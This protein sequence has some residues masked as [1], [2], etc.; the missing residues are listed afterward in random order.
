MQLWGFIRG[1]QYIILLALIDLNLPAL[2]T[3]FFEDA[4]VV[5]QMDIFLGEEIITAVFNF[6]SNE[7]MNDLFDKYSF[8][9][10]N[11][12]LNSG[13][14][15][16][17]LAILLVL[18]SV[19]FKVVNWIAYHNYRRS[20]CRNIGVYAYKNS[21]N[22][23]Q[24]LMKLFIESY[25]ELSFAVC[26]ALKDMGQ[27]ESLSHFRLVFFSTFSDCLS[28]SLTLICS[29]MIIIVPFV[30]FWIF[31]KKCQSCNEAKME[32]VRSQ[33][34][35]FVE[36]KYQDQSLV[37]QGYFMIRRLLTSIILVFLHSN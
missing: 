36:M 18:R 17:P 10:M 22:L 35:F 25:L 14:I 29:V 13:S 34:S 3:V 1:M 37:H 5:A 23:Y 32:F 12:L 33:I 16:I 11:F 27:S 15:I 31:S 20:C 19:F 30:P 2:A 7:P 9:T 21:Q 26:L 6:T 4:I 28:S 24:T 8:S